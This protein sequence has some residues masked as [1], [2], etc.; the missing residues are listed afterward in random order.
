MLKRV[1]REV[2]TERSVWVTQQ[3]LEAGE[4]HA[5]SPFLEA[6]ESKRPA[7][8]S[9]EAALADLRDTHESVELNLEML[10]RIPAERANTLR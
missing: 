5:H 2:E 8:R 4:D 9:V 10:Q 3:P 6:G 7:P 1:A